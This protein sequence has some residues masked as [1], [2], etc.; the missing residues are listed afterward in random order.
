MCTREYATAAAANRS[1]TPSQG[2][3][4]PMAAAKANPAAA[5][6]DGN[7]VEPGI[8][9]LRRT[10]TRVPARSGRWRDQADFTARF[11]SAD[12]TPMAAVP[13]TAAH[14]PAGPPVTRSPVAMASQRRELLAALESRRS[15]SSSDG[16][17]VAATA[18]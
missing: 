6:P 15:G 4:R 12:V 3:S 7:D 1:A 17:G 9:T 5:W 11:T 8:G 10:G 18:A 13:R 14:R 16:V 2:S